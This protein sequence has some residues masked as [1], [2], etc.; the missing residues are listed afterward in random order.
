MIWTTSAIPLLQIAN[1]HCQSRLIVIIHLVCA[2]SNIATS[3]VVGV[4][5]SILGMM[6]LSWTNLTAFTRAFLPTGPPRALSKESVDTCL[7]PASS[8]SVGLLF[9][10]G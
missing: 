1:F 5:F 3:T 9:W 6:S 7:I 8:R 4:D 10:L 2:L